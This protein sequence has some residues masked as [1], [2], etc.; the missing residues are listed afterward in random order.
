[1]KKIILVIFCSFFMFAVSIAQDKSEQQ[2]KLTS[3]RLDQQSKE[4]DAQISSLNKRIAG[5]IKKYNLLKTP[6][7]RMVPYQTKYVLGSDFIELEKH[8][9]LKDDIYSKDVTG[10]EVRK[11]KIYSDGQSVSKIESQIY[12]RDYYSG[13]MNIV[14]IVDP[15]PMS[16]GSDNIIFTHIVNG[17]T[18]LENKKLGD[19]KNT[20]AAS[21]RND[22]KREFLI[23]HLTYF[24]N[25]LLFIAE[26]Y[27]RGLKDA[28][29]GMSEFLKKAI[30]N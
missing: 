3:E 27:Y 25:S 8:T 23:P 7:V 9:F 5:I 20:T 13:A 19:I 12:E 4:L 2:Y 30:K 15:S 26:A 21:I 14:K 18:F 22:V 24:T 28:E 16:E 17:K 10:I 11:I 6:E 1:M 29:S